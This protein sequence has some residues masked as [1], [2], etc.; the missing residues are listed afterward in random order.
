MQNQKKA[1]SAAFFFSFFAFLAQDKQY[2]SDIYLFL[3]CQA[4]LLFL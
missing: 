2:L 4:H 3:T 1:A